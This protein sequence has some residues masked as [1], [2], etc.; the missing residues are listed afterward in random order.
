MNA[1]LA[2]GNRR[3]GLLDGGRL[4]GL[5]DVA[6]RELPVLEERSETVLPRHIHRTAVEIRCI[7]GRVSE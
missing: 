3:I 5:Q 4:C 6:A 1:R 2:R 7:F